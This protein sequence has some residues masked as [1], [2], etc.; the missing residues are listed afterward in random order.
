MLC[1]YTAVYDSMM[2][3]DREERDVKSVYS[4]KLFL[5]QYELEVGE[6]REHLPPRSRQSGLEL[7]VKDRGVEAQDGM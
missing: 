7:E 4:I 2:E 5:P 1:A 3:K 6:P